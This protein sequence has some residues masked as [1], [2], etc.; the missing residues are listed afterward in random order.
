MGRGN[1]STSSE[2]LTGAGPRRGVH[3]LDLCPRCRGRAEDWRLGKDACLHVFHGAAPLGWS[4]YSLLN[5]LRLLG[6]SGPEWATAWDAGWKQVLEYGLDLS[7]ISPRAISRH[8]RALSEQGWV[9]VK[10]GGGRLRFRISD[11]GAEA[12][13]GWAGRGACVS[14]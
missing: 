8:L 10:R 6:R 12:L 9:D 3:G 11:A 13:A 2:L 4:D 7:T 14:L 5:S 1:Q